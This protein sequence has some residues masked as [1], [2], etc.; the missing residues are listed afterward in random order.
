MS[1]SGAKAEIS[2]SDSA[3]G[4]DSGEQKEDV[5]ISMHYN[6]WMYYEILTHYLYLRKS[7]QV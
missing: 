1:V 4:S 2:D 6:I 3:Y 5:D 7:L